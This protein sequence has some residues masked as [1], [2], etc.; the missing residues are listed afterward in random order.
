MKV[1]I[2]K[3]KDIFTERLEE[4]K[5]KTMNRVKEMADIG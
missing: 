2:Q 4:L 1:A 5:N 3:E